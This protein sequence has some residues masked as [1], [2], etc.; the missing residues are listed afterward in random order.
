MV[1]RWYNWTCKK[2]GRAIFAD[3]ESAEK[4][5]KTLN[6]GWKAER[7]ERQVSFS[8]LPISMNEIDLEEHCLQ[9]G[10]RPV[11]IELDKTAYPEHPNQANHLA[12][13]IANAVPHLFAIKSVKRK[14]KGLRVAKVKMYAKEAMQD[15]IVALHHQ[16]LIGKSRLYATPLLVHRWQV[17]PLVAASFPSIITSYLQPYCELLAQGK[18]AVAFKGNDKDSTQTL[19]LST[20]D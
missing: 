6:A 18:L 10:V 5:V 3:A 1:I 13:C 9:T 8:N 12:S 15:L 14:E 11:I 7:L 4:V 19:K 17:E 16:S 20:Q 2:T